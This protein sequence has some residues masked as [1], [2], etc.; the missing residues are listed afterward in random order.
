MVIEFGDWT[1]S[2]STSAIEP[3]EGNV[4]AEVAKDDFINVDGN[5]RE[6]GNITLVMLSASNPKDSDS[7][8]GRCLGIS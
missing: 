5:R 3:A 6:D 8:V 7:V 4:S 2:E 1:D